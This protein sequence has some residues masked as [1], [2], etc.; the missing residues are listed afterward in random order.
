MDARVGQQLGNYRLIRLLGQGGFADVY[1]GEHVHLGTQA[2]LKVLQ[3][4]LMGEHL[5]LFRNEARTIASLV[6]PN[7]VRVFDY[8][9][10]AGTPFLVMEYAP[11]GS[12]RQ[13]Y[14]RGSI[15]SPQQIVAAVK[16]VAAALH[17]AHQRHF[18]HRDVKPEN[19]LLGMNDEILLSDFG[20]VLVEQSTGSQITREAAGTLPYMAPEQLQGK[21]RAASDQYA[22]GIVVYEWLCGERPF[23]GGP[24][25]LMG[26]HALT[27]PPPLRQRVPTIPHTVE[28][29]VLRALSKEPQER[30]ADVVAFATALEIACRDALTQPF[31][32]ADVLPDLRTSLNPSVPRDALPGMPTQ[33]PNELN[34]TRQNQDGWSMS[35]P[36][37][38]SPTVQN[39]EVESPLAPISSAGN[40][41]T[42]TPDTTVRTPSPSGPQT[43]PPGAPSSP[44]WSQAST[45][46]PSTEA[47]PSPD[48]S[49]LPK[50][51]ISR[52]VVIASLVGVAG[53]GVSALAIDWAL[54]AGLLGIHGSST[55]TI[56]PR[57]TV[58][59]TSTPSAASPTPPL[60]VFPSLLYTYTGHSDQV[61]AVAWSADG[62]Y[63]ASAAG[64]SSAY[65]AYPAKDQTVQVWDATNG[66]HIYTYHG[67]GASLYGYGASSVAWSP[68]SKRLVAG[69]NDQSVEIWNALDGGNEVTHPGYGSLVTSVAWSP[70]GSRIA[71]GYEDGK[72]KIWDAAGGGLIKT[73]LWTSFNAC[74]ALAWSPNSVSLA[75]ANSDGTVQ[76]WNAA[77]GG[78]LVTLGQQVQG[79]G[80]YAITWSPDGK[81]IA[82]GGGSPLGG[83]YASPVQ[84]WNVAEKTT[85]FLYTG[86]SHSI[87]AVSWSPDGK[88]I[89]SG[90][91]DRTVQ[92]WAATDGSHAFTYNGHKDTINAVTWSPTSKRVASAS[93]DHTVQVWSIA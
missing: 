29:V 14:T 56:T 9:V 40:T 13:R 59:A 47:S 52:R 35:A 18:I 49:R 84:V 90:G 79:V 64:D 53:L 76:I 92:I 67:R 60:L 20:L 78:Q 68:D 23:R 66:T 43:R 45:V 37:Y 4:R 34:T 89:A 74:N 72:V 22:L 58:H 27:P 55:P 21:P 7:I 2:A 91:S 88:Y 50:H 33:A 75:A 57:G 30:F 63:I 8:G 15:V 54:S 44:S 3:V 81:R 28:A 73:Y 85:A 5:A 87:A 61:R 16:Q 12:L 19:M 36:T 71:S 32:A 65:G 93:N 41:P 26:Q 48:G 31:P 46:T 82:S 42:S 38:V 62:N 17:Y 77:T 51:R 24:M 25:E 11:H 10:E 1:L 69:V 39:E 83:D 80:L 70:D 86:H 6:H